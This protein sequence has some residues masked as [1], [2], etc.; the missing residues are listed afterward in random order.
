MCE[1]M[2]MVISTY[3]HTYTHT[4]THTHE[5]VQ[6]GAKVGLQLSVWKIAQ[7]INNNTGIH[8]FVSP[9]L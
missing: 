9:Q 2:G 4:H 1:H 7:L 8:C 3:L 6:G 5:Y